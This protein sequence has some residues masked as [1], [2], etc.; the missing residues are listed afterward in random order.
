MSNIGTGFFIDDTGSQMDD[1][2]VW[3]II[4]AFYA[5]LHYLIPVLVLF[6][7]GSETEQVRRRLMRRALVDSSVSM[8]IA[9][10]LVI[11]LAGQQRMSAAMAVLF[12]SMLYPFVR[13]W[14]HRRE[15]SATGD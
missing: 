9:F 10:A 7:T 14:L 3:I 4:G 15:I 12:V 6:I 13:I 5:P 11:W 2:I 1:V 8:L